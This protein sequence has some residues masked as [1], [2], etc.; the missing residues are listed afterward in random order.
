MRKEWQ[1]SDTSEN[2]GV[3]EGRN[4]VAEALRAGRT[5]DKVFFLKSDDKMLT[6][7]AMQAKDRG[8][9]VVNCD[10]RKLDQMS[11]TGVHQGII[12]MTAACE[13]VS[14]SDMINSAKESG[15]L[16]LIVVCDE[17][18]DPHNLGAIIR[19]AEAAGANG[20]IIPKRRN[21]GLTAVVEKASA[22]ALEHMPIARVANIPSA[23]KELKDAGLWV[24]GTGLYEESVDLYELDFKC[25]AAIVIGSEG[26]GMGRLV[27][28]SCDF[29]AKI[30]MYGKIQS[31][32]AS[33]AAAVVLFE[34]LRQRNA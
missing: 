10:R 25:P 23:I 5:I 29:V 12:A 28:E 33:A 2:E 20:I 19:S 6:R 27:K 1:Y 8:A 24:F 4:A 22:G 21:A 11:R 7:L 9:V 31:L 18:S 15:R 34:V 16:P 17:I 3:I 26:E 14:V 30:P 13:Y 32:N